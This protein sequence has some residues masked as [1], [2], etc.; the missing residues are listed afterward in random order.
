VCCPVSGVTV[1]VT[2][3][4]SRSLSGRRQSVHLY[5]FFQ[6][7]FF[8]SATQQVEPQ[9]GPA[10]GVERSEP[11]RCTSRRALYMRVWCPAVAVAWSA[12]RARAIKNEVLVPKT[13]TRVTHSHSLTHIIASAMT[14]ARS[15]LNKTHATQNTHGTQK[16]Y[17]SGSGKACATHAPTARRTGR[18]MPGLSGAKERRRPPACRAA[19]SAAR[20][21]VTV[22]PRGMLTRRRAR[23]PCCLPPSSWASL[24]AFGFGVGG[25]VR[26]GSE[27]GPGLRARAKGAG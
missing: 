4:P 24:V 16:T 10:P 14:E 3:E 2:V 23:S 17:A 20:R 22:T 12:P 1:S 15:S 5:P 11:W 8:F 13:L 19:N 7:S 25:G 26:V 6:T 21:H 18:A 9:P 27:P